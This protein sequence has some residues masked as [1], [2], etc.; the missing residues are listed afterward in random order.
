M[1]SRAGEKRQEGPQEP[2]FVR[3]LSH[4]TLSSSPGA[5]ALLAN[6]EAI[7]CFLQEV[8]PLVI[9]RGEKKEGKRKKEKKS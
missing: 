6:V 4:P 2:R 7:F 5:L 8:L 1:L 3:G 9:R